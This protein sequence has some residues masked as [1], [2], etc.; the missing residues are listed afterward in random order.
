MNIF[1]ALEKLVARCPDL[2]E[3]DLSDCTQLTSEAITIV[4]KL[5]KLEYLSL[6][7]CYN[8]SVTSYL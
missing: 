8:I 5:K 4:C 6:S 2:L 3:L 7:R 1:S